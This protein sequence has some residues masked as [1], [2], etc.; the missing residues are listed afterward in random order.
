MDEKSYEIN[1]LRKQITHISNKNKRLTRKKKIAKN[2]QNFRTKH[3]ALSTHTK[4][5]SWYLIPEIDIVDFSYCIQSLFNHVAEQVKGTTPVL[6]DVFYKQIYFARTPSATE[7][8]WK[9]FELMRRFYQGLA[10]KLGDFHEEIIGKFPGFR[11][12]PVGHWS[13]VDIIT[14]DRKLFIEVKNRF[15]IS[16]DTLETV[17]EKFK[18][19]ILHNPETICILVY[20]N[21][22]IGWIAPKPILH[23]KD[24]TVKIDLQSYVASKRLFILDG[25]N[26]YKNICQYANKGIARP[27]DDTFFDRLS[28]TLGNA[29]RSGNFN[30]FLISTEASMIEDL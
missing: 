17:Y 3:S 25:K 13:G 5:T 19:R 29:I 6:D 28:T 12:L 7:A 18:T 30:Q 4:T 11:T 2:L 10:Q 22:P 14:E 15:P 27:E 8:T 21:T 20:I 16:S 9:Q 24:G 26:A 1:I 23:K